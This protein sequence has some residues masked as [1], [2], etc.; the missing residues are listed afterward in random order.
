MSEPPRATGPIMVVLGTRPEAIKMA[1]VVAMLRSRGI[2]VLVTVTAQH[3]DMLDQVLDLFKIEPDRDLDLMRPGQSLGDLFAR[4]LLELQTVFQELRPSMVIVH[5]DTSTTF[6]AG[7]A[8]FYA[9][10]PIAH[11]EA[12][13]RTGNL[14]S[15]FPEEMNRRLVAPLSVL[16]FSPTESARANLIAEGHSPGNIEV[17]GNTV[18]DALQMVHRRLA[19]DEAFRSKAEAALPP[20]LD[21]SKRLILVTG[22]RRENHGNGLDSVCEALR[23]LA[24]RGDV[25]IAYAV[26][27][28]PNVLQSVQRILGAVENVLLTPPLDYAAFICLLRRSCLVIT[29]S[30][31]VQEEAPALAKPVFVTRL[32]SERPEAIVAGTARLVGTDH[33]RIVEAVS[34]VLD[35]DAA[36][37][38]MAKAHNPF[39]DGLA[40]ARIADRIQR[41]LTAG[42]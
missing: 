19:E 35:D 30:G 7:L 37:G 42:R 24:Q 2:R 4:I 21:E 33:D 3:R 40:S 34:A 6:A 38:A 1:P 25:Q 15:P 20:S 5:G 26:H 10:I 32:T 14:G 18:I 36:Y 28:H 41:W 39:G 8:A 29:D 13:L 9:R 31:G 11:V 22:H 27:P 23:S 16:H 17:T 12:G